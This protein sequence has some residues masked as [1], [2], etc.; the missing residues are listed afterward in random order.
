MT[1]A[2]RADV[3]VW[4]T[5][6]VTDDA[7]DGTGTWT[8]GAPNWFNQTQTLQNQVWVNGSDA[9]FGA[10]S[11]TAGTITLSGPITAGNLTFNAATSGSYTLGGSGTL[12]LVD[13]T[14]TSNA[15]GAISAIIAGSTAWQKTGA[16]TL[17]LN[18]SATN[19]HTGNLTLGQGT[20][21]LAKTGGATAVAGNLNITN[22]AFVTFTNGTT[23]QIASTAVVTMSSEASVFNGIGPNTGTGNSL[24]Q[25]L[26]GLT[27]A[28][29]TF[30]TGGSSTPGVGS[31]WNITGA[32]SMTGGAVGSRSVF[33]GNSSTVINVGSLSLVN[34]NGGSSSTAVTNGFTLFGNG[35]ANGTSR[36]TVGS[37]GAYL[38]NSIIYLGAGNT[39]SLLYLDGDVTTGG[40]AASSIQTTGSGTQP[41]VGL[42]TSGA[43]SRTFAVAGGGADLTI[44]VAVTNGTAAS[45]ALVKSGTG[46][47]ILSG[48]TANTYT[49]DTTI[50]AGTLRL[51][52]TAGITAVA[53]DIVVSTGGVLQL[54]T[55]NQIADDK[56]VTLNG[57]TM[58]GWSTDETIAFFT[59]NSGGLASSGNVGH[60]T[61]SGALTL[62]GGNQLVINSNAGSANPASWNVGSA[63]LSGA[64]IL[65]GG[66]NGAGNPRTSL[67]IGAGGLTM[68]GRTITMNVGDAGVIL[69]LNGDFF[70]SGSN[71]ITTNNTTSV[72]PL[73][74]IGSATRTFNIA[75]GGTTTIGVIISGAG[76]NLV[77][78]GAGLMQ[79]TG[80]A[81][82][83]GT[84]TVSGGTLSV[85]ST[86]GG[87]AGTSGLIINNGGIFQNGSPTT[88][89]NNGVANRLNTAATLTLGGGAFNQITA[90][91]GAHTQDLDSVIINGGSNTV[92][93]T[94]TAGT[95][96]ALTF[97]GTDPYVRTSGTVNF[98]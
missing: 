58:T 49:G 86:A 14:I 28:G 32:F 25:T 98:V 55:S 97:T 89:N 5:N 35:G 23:N 94:A 91:T 22:G 85:A 17:T 13:S 10:G 2:T 54:S 30:N 29:G 16:G 60:V 74:E 15:A 64:D 93:V 8:V 4:D 79:I 37:G 42:G 1:E 95:T 21:A 41:A 83:S 66:T 6:T 34:M 59:Q 51:N 7:Q 36:M 92:N 96:N 47:L 75:S 76:G 72:Q 38:Q 31:T 3:L 73:L 57:G 77:K 68:L 12:T 48:G 87:L 78:T 70:G 56:G 26:A 20:L 80:V 40:T 71:N 62:A 82:Y 43:V 44:S 63:I 61:I 18:G 53:G 52:K 69:N 67:T 33:V 46:T 88:S 11:G 45:A 50:N 9:V 24:N 65:I 27:I 39:G 84:T 81:S 90:A 19:T